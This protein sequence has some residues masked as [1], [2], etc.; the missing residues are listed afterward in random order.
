MNDIQFQRWGAFGLLLVVILIVVFT[1]LLPLL[2]A[3]MEY[4]DTKNDLVFRLQ[5]YKKIAARKDLVLNDFKQIKQ[6]YQ[7]QQY[8]STHGTVALV[9]ANLQKIIKT[10]ITEA[11]AQLTSTQVLPSKN[12]NELNQVVIKV[13]MAG[14]IEQLRS[15]IY[16]LETSTPLV[17]LDQ[18]DI[19]PVRGKR[20]RKT[21]KIEASNKL[22]I[23]FQAISFMRAKLNE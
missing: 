5:R 22:N 4:H 13:R 18:I 23:N 20:N 7:Q 2:N 17:I 8:F 10:A 1:L 12:E 3:G 15:I 14:N 19:R 11:G 6:T 16:L 21:R 9:S